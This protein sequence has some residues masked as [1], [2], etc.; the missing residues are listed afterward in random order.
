[1]SD[2]RPSASNQNIDEGVEEPSNAV[3]EDREIASDDDSEEDS[4]DTSDYDREEDSDTTYNDDDTEKKPEV[5]KGQK[6]AGKGEP[7]WKTSVEYYGPYF[8]PDYELLPDGVH[9]YYDNE[10]MK[11]APETE[12]MA[13]LYAKRLDKL[14]V[15]NRETREI[16]DKNFLKDWQNTMTESEKE[17]ITD[18]SKCCFGPIRYHLREKVDEKKSISKEDEAKFGYCTIDGERQQL[19][20]WKIKEPQCCLRIRSKN[21]ENI[22]KIMKRVKPEDVT[23]NCSSECDQ[24]NNFNEKGFK[25]INQPTT[26]YLAKWRNNVTGKFDGN[27]IRLHPSVEGRKKFGC[28]VELSKNIEK[29]RQQY[30]SDLDSSVLDEQQ[31]GVILYILDKFSFRAGTEESSNQEDSTGV[32]TLKKS[33]ITLSNRE[34]KFF[35]FFD[36]IGKSGITYN[37]EHPVEEKVFQIL[38]ELKENGESEDLFPRMTSKKVND[39]LKEIFPDLTI[40]VFRT[41]NASLKMQEELEKATKNLNKGNA[42]VLYKK[43]L[44]EVTKY[45]NHQKA[46]GSH[47]KKEVG[48]GV[49]IMTAMPNNNDKTP[50]KCKKNKVPE[51]ESEKIYK[52]LKTAGGIQWAKVDVDKNSS[53]ELYYS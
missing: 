23:I 50:P 44:C 48:D 22:G 10:R 25:I 19:W 15:I 42:L 46:D 18:L 45:L 47:K 8:P 40:K 43:A 41:Y 13:T 12:E 28:A 5:G 9:F 11:L 16:F 17:R 36:F 20:N 2:T 6:K 35:V 27:Y 26:R 1:M 33:H 52:H 30:R 7:L 38:Q 53:T 21:N 32:C 3:G 24:A 51:E 39:R 14:K 4:S 31:R 37:K 34:G 29:V 49:E